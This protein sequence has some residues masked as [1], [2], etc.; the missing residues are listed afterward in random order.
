MTAGYL[1]VGYFLLF[2]GLIWFAVGLAASPPPAKA[3][4]FSNFFRPFF[5]PP[6]RHVAPPPAPVIP[7]SD[8]LPPIQPQAALPP[9]PPPPDDKPYDDKLMR[10]AE[11]LGSLHYLRELCGANEGQLWRQQMMD[12]VESEGTTAV[13][14]ARL[15]NSFNDGYRGFRRTYR[16]CTDSANVA[17]NRF[18]DEGTKIALALANPSKDSKKSAENNEAK[19][20]PQE[21]AHKEAKP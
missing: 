6:P 5:N 15:I 18:L 11:I 14:R 8:A 21:T 4:F 17:I 1:A 2:A 9:P 7:P 19:K 10:L 3:Q 12:I 20:K 16:T 13:R